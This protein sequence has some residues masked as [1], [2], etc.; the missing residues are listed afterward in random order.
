MEEENN[1][2]QQV[3]EAKNNKKRKFSEVG[4]IEVQ[5]NRAKMQ[6]QIDNLQIENIQLKMKMIGDQILAENEK[7]ELKWNQLRN[8]DIHTFDSIGLEKHLLQ[9]RYECKELSESMEKK[10]DIFDKL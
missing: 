10:L 8:T 7:L 2:K 9:N 3:L 5:L 4:N 6:K 1:V